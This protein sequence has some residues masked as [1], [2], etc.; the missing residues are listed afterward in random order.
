MGCLMVAC[1]DPAGVDVGKSKPRL[2]LAG[3]VHESSRSPS[4]RRCSSVRMSPGVTPL[5]RAPSADSIS[6]LSV[7]ISGS[8]R[9]RSIQISSRT[10]VGVTPSSVGAFIF[11]F[12]P[13]HRDL[14]YGAIIYLSAIAQIGWGE[15]TWRI[16]WGIRNLCP[17]WDSHPKD[18]GNG[19]V[20]SGK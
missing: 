8:R 11:L 7:R 1:G 17:G 16:P 13:D 3:F 2:S 14:S 20:C 19:S 18:G 15:V 4:H 5:S 6:M 10:A 12:F 9:W